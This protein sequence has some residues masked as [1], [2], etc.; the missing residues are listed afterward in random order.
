MEDD[1]WNMLLK[2]KDEDKEAKFSLVTSDK[3]DGQKL[4]ILFIQTNTMQRILLQYPLI[5][6]I[7]MVPIV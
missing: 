1:I 6:L 5:L 2:L 7:L 4:E 3:K